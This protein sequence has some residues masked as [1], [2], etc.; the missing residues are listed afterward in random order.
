MHNP[1]PGSQFSELIRPASAGALRFVSAGGLAT[2]GGR[3]IRVPPH[4]RRSHQARTGRVSLLVW[5]G[6]P[7]GLLYVADYCQSS[8]G[9]R[10]FLAEIVVIDGFKRPMSA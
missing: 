4:V 7:R 6:V 9:A 10:V 5:L 1:D 2:A 8:T 3:G